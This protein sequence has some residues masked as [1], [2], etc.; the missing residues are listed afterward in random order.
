[1]NKCLTVVLVLLVAVFASSV[2]AATNEMAI[3]PTQK[4]DILTVPVYFSNNEPM[5]GIVLFL[6][7]TDLKL[8]T[9]IEEAFDKSRAKDLSFKVVYYIGEQ[10]IVSVGALAIGKND[11]PVE[12]GAGLLANLKFKV[13]GPNPRVEQS[14]LKLSDGNFS[15]MQMVDKDAEDMP[16][17][18]KIGE[19]IGIEELET[20]ENNIPKEF[21]LFGNYPNPFNPQTTI[22][23]ALPERAQVNLKI[24]NIAGQLVWSHDKEFEAGNHSITWN[25]QNNN[26]EIVASGIYLYKL[27][28]GKHSSTQKMVL[29]K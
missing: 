11:I 4:G 3:N 1:M 22:A 15:E 2:W 29:V 17:E 13:I 28:A 10:N 27:V 12:P 19:I 24:Y 6:K 20:G 23:F 16:F 7:I 26:G 14:S 8:I 25:S 18:F 9:T 5:A 21:A